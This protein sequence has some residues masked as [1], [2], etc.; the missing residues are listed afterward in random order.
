MLYVGIDQ[1]KRHLTVCVRD[2]QGDIVL[3]R[4]VST[5]WIDVARFLSSLK[6]RAASEGGFVAVLEVCGFNDW[7]VKRLD[8]AGCTR[9]FVIAAPPQLRNKTDRR[10]AA[11]LSELLWINRERIATGRRMVELRVV[12]QTT[13]QE[14]RGRRLVRLRHDLGRQGTRIKNRMAAILRRYNM[15]RGCPT[16]SLYTLRGLRWLAEIELPELDRAMLDMELER[17]KLNRS[18]LKQVVGMIHEHA[19]QQPTIPLLRT[20]PKIGEYTAL[21]LWAHIGPI[22]RFPH[23]RSVANYFGLTPGCRN[24][25]E[26][27]RPCGITKAGH[28]IVRF[29]LGQAVVHA[30]RG[31]PG[32]RAWY[33]QV[34]RRRGAKIARVGVMRR[35]CEALWHM[36]SKQEPYKPVGKNETKRSKETA[37]AA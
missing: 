18:H 23:A 19:Q 27:D 17:F 4:Q 6:K 13:E 34:K 32:L 29:L 20:L 21:A 9:T 8:R 30:L 15:E 1:H 28:P 2:E 37:C 3:R 22:E 10:D 5:D 36:L 14:E 16:K 33:R 11:K 35:L 31:D 25:G 12:Y 7:L 26:A 24:S